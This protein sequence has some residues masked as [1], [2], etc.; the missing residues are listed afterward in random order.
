[1]NS[2][3]SKLS[4][5]EASASAIVAHAEQGKAGINKEFQEK[6]NAFDVELA[7]R[8]NEQ[9]QKIREELEQNRTE[10]LETQERL[11]NATIEGLQADFDANCSKYVQ[12]IL[13]KITT[14]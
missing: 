11:S 13:K 10:L 5:I 6:T 14:V 3:V 2:I 1:M 12:A 8:T 4:E 7:T 9:I